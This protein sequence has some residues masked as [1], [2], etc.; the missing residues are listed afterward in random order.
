MI[1]RIEKCIVDTNVSLLAGTHISKIKKEQVECA[2]ACIKFIK[3][4]I[5]NPN[6][7][8]V[9]DNAGEVLREYRKATT[10]FKSERNV[11]V[12]FYMWVC[13]YIKFA[14]IDN[15]VQLHKN[16]QNSF[17]E[18]PSNKDLRDFDPADKKFI[19]LANAHPEHPPIIEGSDSE[20]WGIRIALQECGL[21]VKFLC[22]KYIKA[23]YEQKRG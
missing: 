8:I 2:S 14:S 19:A 11:A 5:G 17:D 12:L 10:M 22:E 3:N 7:K 15:L 4:F 6:S 23:K 13:Q 9:L 21:Q 16:E 18:Y 20:W 1:N